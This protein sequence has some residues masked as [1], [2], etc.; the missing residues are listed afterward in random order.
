M[1]A[2]HILVAALTLVFTACASD[3]GGFDASGVFET[4]EVIVSAQTTGQIESLHIEEGQTVAPGNPLGHID[5]T[6]LALQRQQLNATLL[7]TK[8]KALDENRQVASLRQQIDNLKKERCRFADLLAA[9]AATRKQVD[10]IDYQIEVLTRQLSATQEQLASANT[11]VDHQADAIRAQL[12]QI[13]DQIRKAHITS[14]IA[15]TILTRY[16]EQ[17][18][19]ATPGKPLFKV[20]DVK[21]MKL[22]VYVT[23]PQ[24]TQLKIGQKVTV[25]A[26]RGEADRQAYDGI[27]EWI[28]EKAEFTPKTIQT[29]DERANLVYAVKI[30]VTNDGLIK[31]GMYGNVKF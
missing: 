4:T 10:D 27:V 17:G 14:P 23:A 20:S 28:A 25:F 3:D 9:D 2:K 13:D 7:A 8:N 18:E 22:R 21:A 19:Y 16:A 6:Q 12:A 24:L 11:G 30:A 29:R 1:K 26:D 31:R 15:G 5:T